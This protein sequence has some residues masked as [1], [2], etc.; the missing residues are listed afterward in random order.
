[1]KRNPLFLLSM[2]LTLTANAQLNVPKASPLCTYSQRV[3]LTDIVLSFSRPAVNNRRIFGDL[4]PF[5]AYWRLGAN[6]NTKITTNDMLIFGKDTLAAGTYA[7]FAKPGQEQWTIAFYRDYNNWGLP[8]P[9]DAKKVVFECTAPIQWQA[10]KTE[11][12]TLGI[13]EIGNNGALLF[14][15]WDNARVNFSF[16]VNTLPKVKSSIEKVMAGPTA[17]DYHAAAKYYYDEKINDEK[18]LEWVDLA[19]KARPEA[20]WMLRTKSLIQASLGLYKEAVVTAELCMKLAE[21]DGDSAY[22]SQCR[23]SIAEWKKK[24]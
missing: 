19:I 3:G 7:I 23:N 21:A 9:W 15:A 13:D 8:D 4:I 2:L 24:K 1:M 10:N 22:V 12:L 14:M 6:E 18:A 11:N 20:Y 5:D 17:N 16:R